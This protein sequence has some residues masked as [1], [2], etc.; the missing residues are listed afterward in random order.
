MAES[1]HLEPFVESCIDEDELISE[2]TTM[3]LD[4]LNSIFC[5]ISSFYPEIE[6]EEQII[7]AGLLD[8]VNVLYFIMTTLGNED[9][10]FFNDFE[11]RFNSFP[12][13]QLFKRKLDSGS[14]R[15]GMPGKK[16]NILYI[17]FLILQLV[18]NVSAI[19]SISAAGIA[20]TKRIAME[21]AKQ[22]EK[23]R[24]ANQGKR[25]V[26]Y[27]PPVTPAY[28]PPVTPAIT[29]PVCPVSLISAVTKPDKLRPEYL[30]TLCS[31]FYNKDGQCA[32]SSALSQGVS[33]EAVSDRMVARTDEKLEDKKYR[34]EPGGIFGLAGYGFNETITI[35]GQ[36]PITQ[37]VA[38][39]TSFRVPKSMF[40][41]VLDTYFGDVTSKFMELNPTTPKDAVIIM[42]LGFPGH[43]VN[44]IAREVNG[45]RLYGIIDMNFFPH[46]VTFAAYEEYLLNN[47]Q[48]STQERSAITGEMTRIS[49]ISEK[50]ISIQ[51]GFFNSTE[52]STM[53]GMYQE[54]PDPISQSMTNNK[55]VVTPNVI[56][57]REVHPTG[58][59]L[60]FERL[61]IFAISEV[62]I[63]KF[64]DTRTACVT[65]M[66]QEN[67][68]RN[69]LAGG[70][71]PATLVSV[72]KILSPAHGVPGG[73]SNLRKKRKTSKKSKRKMSRTKK[74]HR[75]MSRKINKRT[76]QRR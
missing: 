20:E 27:T 29:P 15:G 60:H 67:N 41:T 53:G 66:L 45:T 4:G 10:N 36:Q 39:L 14:T 6:T 76:K 55:I 3:I 1:F 25:L 57:D 22:Q 24:I 18:N 51:P 54:T 40:N 58:P 12:I 74:S 47:P 30:S 70:G 73:G 32:Y 48:M 43:A 52:L 23:L 59:G 16:R 62:D 35:P 21:A 63:N 19:A 68:T 11:T 17:L 7:E 72:V 9:T 34:L 69:A 28:F 26:S 2:S 71:T 13:Y 61:P 44:C 56:V 65:A 49:P 42:G 46:M 50:F 37:R 8:V 5:T 38:E 75:K 64:I 31:A 33:L